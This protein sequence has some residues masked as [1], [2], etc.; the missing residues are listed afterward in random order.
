MIHSYCGASEDRLPTEVT[1]TEQT[2]A[3]ERI[4]RRER[5]G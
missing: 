1:M 3:F 2:C 4:G 5:R